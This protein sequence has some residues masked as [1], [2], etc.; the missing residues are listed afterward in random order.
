MRISEAL[1]QVARGYFSAF[2]AGAGLVLAVVLA[3][4]L[5]ALVAWPLWLAATSSPR[6]Y[7][8]AVLGLVLVGIVLAAARSRS[9]ARRSGARRGERL[10]P[11]R[12]LALAAC[13]VAVAPALALA[14]RLP[15][16]G[17]PIAAALVL[18]AGLALF[19]RSAP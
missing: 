5:S 11:A 16:V 4:G 12:S 9:A 1:G 14:A 2:R 13:M 15:W 7:A 10:G 19:A 8:F 6:A 3:G 18:A 17:I